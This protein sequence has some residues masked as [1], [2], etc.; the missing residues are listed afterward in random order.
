[1]T[2]ATR[3][4][5]VTE[6]GNRFAAVISKNAQIEILGVYDTPEEAAMVYDTVAFAMFGEDAILNFSELF[7]G[8]LSGLV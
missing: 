5:G 4:R 8:D 6:Y 1:M 3:Y 7:E 2:T